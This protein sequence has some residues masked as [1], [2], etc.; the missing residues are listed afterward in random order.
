LNFEFGFVFPGGSWQVESMELQWIQK[1]NE[2]EKE[3]AEVRKMA[4]LFR[5]VIGL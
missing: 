1:E 2:L 4:S 3:K 5:Q